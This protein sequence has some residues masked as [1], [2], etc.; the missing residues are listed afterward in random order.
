MPSVML[1]IWRP[2]Q[3]TD[4]H[5]DS[6]C[7]A[8]CLQ[9]CR[10]SQSY[11]ACRFGS[12]AAATAALLA[13]CASPAA[14]QTRTT[15]R[16]TPPGPPSPPAVGEWQDYGSQRDPYAKCISSVSSE[17]SSSAINGMAGIM[18]ELHKY[19]C[20]GVQ[21]PAE[22]VKV[23]DPVKVN[24]T[25]N[26]VLQSHIKCDANQ[27]ESLAC[28]STWVD[29]RSFA[30]ASFDA[31]ASVLTATC[32]G[33]ALLVVP[34]LCRQAQLHVTD[35]MQSLI[36]ILNADNHAQAAHVSLRKCVG[37]AADT[38]QHGLMCRPRGIARA[39]MSSL[40]ALTQP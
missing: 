19:Y 29:A 2:C 18:A 13:A 32:F 9:H 35:G 28:E 25:A 36:C 20:T 33:D 4:A 30:Q 17:T 12:F 3:S 37:C 22:M 16:R 39:R 1:I 5:H 23:F 21:D 7:A 24:A 27:Q 10:H 38:H 26:L 40:R 31:C 11:C 34:C 15:S 6:G 14:A 8:L